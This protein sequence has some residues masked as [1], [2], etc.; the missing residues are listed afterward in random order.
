[1][2]SSDPLPKH[3]GAIPSTDP[4]EHTELSAEQASY[5]YSLAARE[6]SVFQCFA[7]HCAGYI[8]LIAALFTVVYIYISD[9]AYVSVVV[10][11]E[12]TYVLYV[13]RHAE[14][15]Q[16]SAYKCNPV[17]DP[18]LPPTIGDCGKEWGDNRCGGEYLNNAGL[19]RAKCIAD[20]VS[21]EGLSYIYTQYPG[22]C[23]DHHIKREYQTMIPLSMKYNMTL[24]VSLYRGDDYEASSKIT[25]ASVRH[26]LCGMKKYGLSTNNIEQ[27][28]ST[29]TGTGTGTILPSINTGMNK[30]KL[31]EPKPKK[32]IVICWNHEDIPQ[33]LKFLGCD[34]SN[35]TCITRLPVTQ[36]DVYYKISLSCVDSSIVN[37]DLLHE[38]CTPE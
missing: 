5:K 28:T 18:K 32:S 11:N 24:D 29:G 27:T 12:D 23:Y 35:P 22:T 1:M 34:Q 19:D 7:K 20:N 2:S 31:G 30:R 3:Y 15:H 9:M 4:D 21:F 6:S 33:L 10:S 36:Y 37:I 17:Q 38:H 8:F 14:D 16:E 13:V 25:S 26:E